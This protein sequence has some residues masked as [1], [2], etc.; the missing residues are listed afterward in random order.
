MVR[1]NWTQRR[2]GMSTRAA[3]RF[4]ACGLSLLSLGSFALYAHWYYFTRAAWELVP[5]H[6][7]TSDPAPSLRTTAACREDTSRPGGFVVALRFWEQQ[8]QALKS[9]AQLQCLATRMGMQVLE[10]FLYRSLLGLPS[11]AAGGGNYLHVSDLIDVGVWNREAASTYGLL[12][13]AEW[14]E[15]LRNAPRDAILL[16]VKHRDPSHS[17]A[18][19]AL[20]YTEGCPGTCFH[21]FGKILKALG[22]HRG[23]F[24]V[25]KKACANFVD[26]V[27][28]VSEAD[29]IEDILADHNKQRVTVFINEFRGFYGTFR[30]QVASYCGVNLHKPNLTVSPSAMIV[31]DAKKY[32]DQVLQGERFVAVLVRVERVVLHLNHNITECGQVLRSV[33]Q[34]LSLQRN[35]IQQFVAMDVGKFGSRGAIVHHLTPSVYGTVVLD[36]VYGG[37]MSFSKWESTFEKYTSRKEGAYVANLQRAIASQ[38]ECLVMVGAGGF[39]GQ[40]RSLYEREHPDRRK[41]CIHK[42]CHEHRGAAPIHVAFSP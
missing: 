22:R 42:I 37:S 18:P 41:R 38:A 13:L 24:R 25:V 4:L 6:I 10:P 16:C 39:Q 21:S 28:S 14:S 5:V 33:L 27:G 35:V 23:K 31:N 7:S 32:V 1:S 30:A 15:F 3:V 11:E 19:S 12:P 20:R 34:N 9:L 40:A 26:Y 17:R 36:A 29:F 2:V 8:T